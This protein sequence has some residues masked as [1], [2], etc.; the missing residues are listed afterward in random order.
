[1][2]YINFKLRRHLLPSQRIKVEPGPRLGTV[3]DNVRA[4]M[5]HYPDIKLPSEFLD[6]ALRRVADVIIREEWFVGFR[7]SHEC[8]V[9]GIGSLAGDI[10]SNMTRLV[11]AN[12]GIQTTPTPAKFVLFG[13]HQNT[14]GAMLI[15]LSCFDETWPPFTSHVDIELFR[16]EGVIPVRART[17]TSRLDGIGRRPFK[18]LDAEEKRRLD[19]Y[20]IRVKYNDRVLKV[21]GC[22]GWGK[23]L[24][25]DETFCTLVRD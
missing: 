7:E 12:L 8:R 22:A 16:G 25:G 23:H 14:I 19:G 15:S 17:W 6:P 11:D 24:H 9:L 4:S 18:E 10:V 3:M 2:D 21:P 1:M 5:A 20:Y 13:A